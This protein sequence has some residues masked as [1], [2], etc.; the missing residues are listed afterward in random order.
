MPSFFL[1]DE[2]GEIIEDCIS[3]ELGGND[4]Y[5]RAMLACR[6]KGTI[7]LTPT[8]ASNWKRLEK[9]AELRILIAGT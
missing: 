6:G 7:Y 1:K 8:W 4:A 3:A 2:N 9:E 5:A